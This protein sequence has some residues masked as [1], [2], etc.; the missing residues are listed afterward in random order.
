[1]QFGIFVFVEAQELNF[2]GNLQ[3]SKCDEDC[4]IL[5]ELFKVLRKSSFPTSSCS[6]YRNIFTPTP[7]DVFNWSLLVHL[8]L[9]LKCSQTCHQKRLKNFSWSYQRNRTPSA[10][11]QSQTPFFRLRL[12]ACL[13][14]KSFLLKL[15]GITTCFERDIFHNNLKE[16]RLWTS[17]FLQILHVATK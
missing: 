7:D 13:V 1:M 9:Y 12:R 10:K 14:I 17:P 6:F 2:H 8:Q 16:K 3:G 15:K 5:W 11:Y 4:I